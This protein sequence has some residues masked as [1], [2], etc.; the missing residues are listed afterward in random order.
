MQIQPFCK[1][2]QIIKI[3][4]PIKSYETTLSWITK[5]SKSCKS[6]YTKQLCL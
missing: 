4:T 3:R 5:L 6:I 1:G 2:H